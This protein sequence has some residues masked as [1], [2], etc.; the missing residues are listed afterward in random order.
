MFRLGLL[1]ACLMVFGAAE[2]RAQSSLMSM[3]QS[4]SMPMHGN[5]CGP[6]H[7]SNGFRASLAPID[8]V[9]G[10]CR[11]HD[12]CYIAAGPLNCS[13]DIQLMGRLRHLRYPNQHLWTVGRAMYDALGMSP[14]TSPQGMAFKQSRVWSDFKDDVTSGRATP[15]DLPMRMMYLGL[16]TLRNKSLMNDWRY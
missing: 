5:W 13:C 6:G 1:L 14:C 2:A 9:D 16:S 12:L 3:P 15:F 11:E 4:M 7:P 8:P 10:A